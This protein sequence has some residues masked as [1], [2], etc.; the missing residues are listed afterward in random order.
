MKSASSS[1]PG[2]ST[3]SA[4]V[5]ILVSTRH[6]CQ[7]G[8]FR[9]T[10]P[11]HQAYAPEIK[12]MLVIGE[13]GRGRERGRQTDRERQRERETEGG[14]E[15]EA[16]RQTEGEKQTDGEREREREREKNDMT[17]EKLERLE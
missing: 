1:K 10:T 17:K 5:V 2:Q 14:R 11:V 13:L 7:K 4:L 9:C 6:R 3:W 12:H 16:D 8:W 15:R